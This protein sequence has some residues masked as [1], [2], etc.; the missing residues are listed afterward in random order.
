LDDAIFNFMRSGD[1]LFC[2]LEPGNTQLRQDVLDH[3]GFVG[4]GEAFF[5]AVVQYVQGVVVETK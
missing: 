2:Q 5:Q 4:A 3:L 1:S